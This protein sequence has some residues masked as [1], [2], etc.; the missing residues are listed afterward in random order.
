MGNNSVLKLVSVVGYPNTIVY[1]WDDLFVIRT[2]DLKLSRKQA[3]SL[4]DFLRGQTVPFIKGFN[5]QD[6]VY[7]R[8]Y[9]HWLDNI[10]E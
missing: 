8:D 10:K 2:S 4:F 3:D 1:D 7:F 9:R 5:L 6:F